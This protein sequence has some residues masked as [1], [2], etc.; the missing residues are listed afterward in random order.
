ME[1]GP[2]ME[3]GDTLPMTA[4]MNVRVARAGPLA[5]LRQ[6]GHARILSPI[7]SEQMMSTAF[8]IHTPAP[9]E[10]GE[11][12]GFSIVA[13]GVAGSGF[14]SR[15]ALD[16]LAQGQIGSHLGIFERNLGRIQEAAWAKWSADRSLNPVLLEE[17]D[18]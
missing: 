16:A 2:M 8:Q 14:V 10:D 7:Q 12:I 15:S 3:S 13:D 5:L 17:H 18:F 11:L 1:E 4:C 9:S 6:A